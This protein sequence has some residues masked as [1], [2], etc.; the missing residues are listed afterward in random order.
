MPEG[1]G[2]TLTIVA[3]RAVDKGTLHSIYRQALRYIPESDLTPHFF[4]E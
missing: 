3:H 4:T 2:Q 1:S